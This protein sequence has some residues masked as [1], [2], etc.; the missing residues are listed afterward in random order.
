MTENE[1]MY[2][3][4]SASNVKSIVKRIENQSAKIMG[5]A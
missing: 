3:K 4:R 1:N 2:Q 5:E